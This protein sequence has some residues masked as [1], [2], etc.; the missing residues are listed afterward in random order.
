MKLVTYLQYIPLQSYLSHSVKVYAVNLH[1]PTN[2]KWHILRNQCCR[3]I[4]L[5]IKS[6]YS[7]SLFETIDVNSNTFKELSF[8]S[9]L[10]IN[11]YPQN[12]ASSYPNDV[13]DLVEM[14][15]VL[16]S[17]KQK[18]LLTNLLKEDQ[19]MELFQKTLINLSYL[20]GNDNYGLQLHKFLMRVCELNSS[21]GNKMLQEYL[22]LKNPYLCSK[23]A[24]EIA[25][26]SLT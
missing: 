3:Y 1:K 9:F 2:K 8:I 18:Q 12:G 21:V 19:T 13:H 11:G 6:P 17:T 5:I 23:I 14:L 22:Q 7:N 15:Q 10:S 4:R 16:S 26:S 25:G 20:M 24:A